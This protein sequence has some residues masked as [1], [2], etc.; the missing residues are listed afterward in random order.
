MSKEKVHLYDRTSLG[1]SYISWDWAMHCP[2]CK[3]SHPLEAEVLKCSEGRPPT[4]CNVCIWTCSH[5][6][7]TKKYKCWECGT[8]WT[9]D[10]KYG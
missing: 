6:V 10:V 2:K 3:P 7:Y 4:F 8:E 1:L 9:E 5:V